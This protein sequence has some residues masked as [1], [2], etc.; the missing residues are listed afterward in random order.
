MADQSESPM[1]FYAFTNTALILSKAMET[2]IFD[3]NDRNDQACADFVP[4]KPTERIICNLRG[5]TNLIPPLTP[6]LHRRGAPLIYI[7]HS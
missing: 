3:S 6:F 2:C 4:A 7:L 1:D 5:Q